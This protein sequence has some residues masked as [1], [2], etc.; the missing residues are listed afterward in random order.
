M[1]YFEYIFNTCISFTLERAFRGC[2]HRTTETDWRIHKRH[3]GVCNVNTD[4]YLFFLYWCSWVPVIL[5]CKCLLCL[6]L[7]QYRMV[8][9]AHG[10]LDESYSPEDD[11]QEVHSVF[12]EEGTTRRSDN[13]VNEMTHI[14]WC[15]QTFKKSFKGLHTART[16]IH[17]Y[18]LPRPQMKKPISR[19]VMPSDSMSID[20]GLSVP[21][22]GHYSA[23]LDRPYR[24]PVPDYPTATVP[25]NYHYGPVGAYDDYR[26]G[27]PSEAYTSLSR[28]AHMDDRYRY[29]SETT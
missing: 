19:T 23:T 6:C 22:M 10:A 18:C 7:L 20:G 17:L 13:G 4:T 8:D 11:S 27:P 21:G 16:Y 1:F 2:R 3:T 28:G 25:R 26:G 9:P 14:R 29:R 12:S 5:R 15:Y 24:Q